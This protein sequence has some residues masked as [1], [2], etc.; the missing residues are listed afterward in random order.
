MRKAVKDALATVVVHQTSDRPFGNLDEKNNLDR[1]LDFA[2]TAILKFV[3]PIC[4]Q[5]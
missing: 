3:N 2:V 1:A 5:P 4:D